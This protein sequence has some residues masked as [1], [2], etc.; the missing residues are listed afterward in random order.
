MVS[1]AATSWLVLQH[2]SILLGSIAAV[3]HDSGLVTLEEGYAI[4][5]SRLAISA[6]FSRLF[7]ALCFGF[8]VGNFVLEF[9][10]LSGCARGLA[11]VFLLNGIEAV[12]KLGFID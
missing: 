4:A 1:R 12:P 6:C 9:L 2:V 8:G 7:L 3:A 11:F 10:Y 5:R